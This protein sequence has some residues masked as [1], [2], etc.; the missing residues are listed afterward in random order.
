M[1]DKP[2]IETDSIDTL[3]PDGF[4]GIRSGLKE[5]ILGGR[6]VGCDLGVYAYLLISANWQTGIAYTCASAIGK[7]LEIPTTSINNSLYRMR[8]RGFINYPKGD[9]SRGL[10][11]VYIHKARPT[12]GVLRGYKLDAFAHIP[13]ER[14]HYR[15]PDG[16]T[17]VAV[18]KPCAEGA[19]VRLMSCGS[20]AL[21]VRIQDV[22][23]VPEG[24]KTT[25]TSKA[26]P[27]GV[28]NQTCDHGKSLDSRGRCAC[29]A[30]HERRAAFEVE[31][32]LR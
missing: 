32:E 17:T 27:A 22:K 25:K 31:E 30:I 20:R 4:T 13:L 5:H 24:S 28:A 12:V 9:G 18:W 14:I 15:Q 16:G 3:F 19:E 6:F 2:K 10:Y 23:D 21:V 8:E 29:P 1:T 26:V 7:H 11:A